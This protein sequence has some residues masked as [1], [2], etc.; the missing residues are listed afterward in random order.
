VEIFRKMATTRLQGEFECKLDAKF[1]VLFPSVLSKQLPPAAKKKFV[2]NRGFEKCLILYPYNEWEAISDKINRKN[3][4]V[5]KN[6]DFVRYF[7]RGATELS[8]DGN[9]RIL[10]PKRLLDYAQIDK[11]LVLYAYSNKIEVWS[12]KLYENLMIDEPNDFSS[13]A[14]EVMNEEQ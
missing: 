1:R 13:L 12:K 9:N 11:E 3:W 14:E 2:I 6:R 8:L 5:K 7:Y 10:L 4:Y